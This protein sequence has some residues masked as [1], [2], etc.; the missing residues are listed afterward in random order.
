MTTESS[1]VKQST[2]RMVLVAVVALLLVIAVTVG[3]QVLQDVTVRGA[4]DVVE[5]EVR[6]DGSLVL[7]VDSCNGDPVASVFEQTDDQVRIEV[8]ASSTPFGG[9]GDCLD[10]VE[11][12]LQ[13]PL[14][15]RV[16]VDAHTESTVSVRGRAAD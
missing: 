11:V 3:W 13:K 1:G 5:A 15:D 8:V 14:G 4:V 7:E 2:R 6:D 16:V 12:A 10:I 9:G